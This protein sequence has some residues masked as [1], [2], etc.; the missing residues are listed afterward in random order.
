MVKKKEQATRESEATWGGVLQKT[1]TG[2]GDVHRSL[3]TNM[4]QRPSAA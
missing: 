4:I 1:G 3:G 2:K